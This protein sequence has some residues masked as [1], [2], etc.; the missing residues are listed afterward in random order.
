[1]DDTI[2]AIATP[3][4]EG[5]I[6]IVRVS[7]P[8]ALDVAS[9]LF[10]FRR[11][12]SQ[13][14]PP[15]NFRARHAYFGVI[16]DDGEIVDE[17][18]LTAFRKPR[19]YTTEDMVEISCHGGPSIAH[20]ILTASIKSGCR[21]ATNG[22]FTKRAFLNGRIDL[23][24]A[25]AVA[26]L[27]RSSSDSSRQAAL[28]QLGGGLSR[29]VRTIYDR[30]QE[31]L[32][33]IEASIDFPEEDGVTT[34]IS[35]LVSSLQSITQTISKIIEQSN[36]SARLREGFRV[37][38]AGIPN[39]G[40]STLFNALIGHD[41]AIVSPIPGTTR[42]SISENLIL[43]GRSCRIVDTAGLRSTDHEVEKQGI[44]RTVQACRSADVVLV[45]IDPTQGM[46]A[47]QIAQ[48]MELGGHSHILVAN[49]TDLV[50]SSAEL[51]PRG[52]P[53]VHVSAR[54]GD[55]MDLLRS[56]I[57]ELTASASPTRCASDYLLNARQLAALLRSN[58]FLNSALHDISSGAPSDAIA[59]DIRA[60][61]RAVG[62]VIGIGAT[63]NLLESIFDK[64]CIGK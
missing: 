29:I 56:R 26:E 11:A 46:V 35:A 52:T 10:R 47:R 17:V 48:G 7:G 63:S 53:A 24:Q 34:D 51:L 5:A 38:I 37:V 15:E 16:A 2:S 42:D 49:K 50:D 19:S 1:M 57:I 30:L 39:C 3:I 31:C 43:G 64:F 28:S 32:A 62:D 14:I 27:I 22:E 44:E 36:H 41:R 9:R 6:A 33:S 23:T 59:S 21:P 12:L 25:E 45:V 60:A 20:R 4:G 40:K 54:T 18:I 58:I 8:Q 61:S 55:G 13:T